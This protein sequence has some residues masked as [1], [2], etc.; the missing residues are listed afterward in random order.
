MGEKNPT[1]ANEWAII[2]MKGISPELESAQLTY[3]D[4]LNGL[5]WNGRGGLVAQAGRLYI[6]SRK[7]WTPWQPPEKRSYLLRL[8]KKDGKW[9]V[10]LEGM[11]EEMSKTQLPL[12][13]GL[14]QE[15]S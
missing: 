12:D 6:S 9:I 10:A 7:I 8:G 2:E 4:K 1:N 11:N 13:L 14:T 3:A 5:E 15:S